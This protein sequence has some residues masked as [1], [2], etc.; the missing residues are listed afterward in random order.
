MSTRLTRTTPIGTKYRL[1]PLVCDSDV[2]IH[3]ERPQK[4]L[5]DTGADVAK[6]RPIIEL[7]M[8]SG[9]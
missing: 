3:Q 4:R 6:V 9:V 5:N 7:S 1:Q 8:R 2:K